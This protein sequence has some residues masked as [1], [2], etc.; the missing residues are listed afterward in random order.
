VAVALPFLVEP[1]EFVVQTRGRA[2]P[3]LAGELLLEIAWSRLKSKST[4][5]A[6]ADVARIAAGNGYF[7]T[8]RQFGQTKP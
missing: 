3:L 8:S 5:G 1:L 6:A 2:E 7:C 4:I